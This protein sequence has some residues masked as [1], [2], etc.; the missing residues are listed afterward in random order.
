MRVKHDRFL[1]RLAKRAQRDLAHEVQQNDLDENAY[2][3]RSPHRVMSGSVL[4]Q[5]CK[6]AN[7]AA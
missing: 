2:R 1:L 7:C 4:I 3:E 5:P 6:H